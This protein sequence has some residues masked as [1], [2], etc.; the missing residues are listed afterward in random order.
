MTGQIGIDGTVGRMAS[1]WHEATPAMVRGLAPLLLGEQAKAMRAAKELAEKG[2]AKNPERIAELNRLYAELSMMAMHRIIAPYQ[3]Q[4]LW[5]FIQL[6]P[7]HFGMMLADDENPVK[8]VWEVKLTRNV[9]PKVRAGLRLLHGPN[10]YLKG[11]CFAEYLMAQEAYGDWVRTGQREH[12]CQMFAIMYR[13]ERKDIGKEH[14]DYAEDS[15]ELF[16]PAWVQ[17][18]VKLVERVQDDILLSLVLYWQGCHALMKRK[19]PHIFTGNG[20]KASDPG[21]VIVMLAKSP[22]RRDVQDAALSPVHNV[23]RRMN[24]DAEAEQKRRRKR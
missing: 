22:N 2:K 13:P 9:L 12:L 17:K 18:R 6:K 8:W 7:E 4:F 5:K 1:G 23:L 19:Y 10:H 20:G 16:V 24:A 14:P 3:F 15:R 11:V 21:T